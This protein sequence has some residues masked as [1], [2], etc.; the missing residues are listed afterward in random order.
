M[1]ESKG[2][3]A[4]EIAAL[5]EEV[6]PLIGTQFQSLSLPKVAMKAFEPSQIG[7]IVGS[8][9]DALIPHLTDIP[10]V[11]L[12]KHEGILGDREGYPDY[13]HDSGFRAELK[14]LYIDNPELEMKRPPTKREPSAR[15]TQKVTVK[16]VVPE[17]DTMLVIAYQLK[18]HSENELAMTPTIVD[19]EVFSM[20]ELVEARDRRLVDGGGRWFGN[21]ETP[22]IVSKK[23]SQKL[24]ASQPLDES[25]YGRKESEGKDF[26]EDTNFGKLKRIPHP[27]LQA[28]LKKCSALGIGQDVS[29]FD[30]EGDGDV[31]PEPIPDV[32]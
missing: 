17:T 18:P 8:L 31:V 24:A 12:H 16:N 14:L 32:L 15:L 13:K 11:G 25:S 2:V 7:T 19:L 22:C 6:L 23:G 5:R 3:S 10:Q 26:N 20:T 21:Y 30:K 27:G 1:S 29:L 28:F 9:M 4:P